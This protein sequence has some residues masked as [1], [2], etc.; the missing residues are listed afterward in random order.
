M[1][2]STQESGIN[3]RDTLA[4]RK[5]G[6]KWDAELRRRKHDSPEGQ[7]RA[8]EHAAMRRGPRMAPGRRR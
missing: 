8:R 2:G 7:R 6:R 5:I 4:A 1:G 3:R